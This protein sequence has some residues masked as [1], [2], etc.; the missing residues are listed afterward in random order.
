MSAADNPVPSMRSPRMPKEVPAGGSSARFPGLEQARSDLDS[1]RIEHLNISRKIVESDERIYVTDMVVMS[2]IQ[3]SYGVIDALIDAID[4]YNVHA[5]APLL[6]L[7][8]DTLFRICYLSSCTDSEGLS[9]KLLHGE[10]FRNMT[11]SSGKKLN[12]ARLQQLAKKN[13]GWAGTVYRETS[14]WVHFSLNHMRATTQVVERELF[15]SVPMR[16]TVLPQSFWLDVY[17][18]ASKSTCEILDYAVGWAS[19]KGLPEGGTRG[20]T[21]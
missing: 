17:A 19:R 18:A 10:E 7:Q 14:G 8:L 21:P 4:N 11:D 15:M 16:P 13:H 5:A 9:E 12:D 20:V 6:R 1:L 3:R 2:M